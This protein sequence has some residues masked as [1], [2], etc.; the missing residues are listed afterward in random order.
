VSGKLDSKTVN[1]RRS[2]KAGGVGYGRICKDH[3]RA[4]VDRGG[5]SVCP[6]CERLAIAKAEAP[7]A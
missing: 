7:R 2:A 3:D 5:H 6:V 4:F 1:R